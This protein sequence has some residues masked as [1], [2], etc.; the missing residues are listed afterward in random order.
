MDYFDRLG[1]WIE[2]RWVTREEGELPDLAVAALEALPPREQLDLEA[3]IEHVL[4]PDRPAQRQLAPLGAFGQ[5]GFTAYYGRGFVVDVY[6]WTHALSAIHDHPFRGAFTLLAGSS[7]HARYAFE[8]EE[9]RGARVRLG[10]IALERLELL[11]AGHVERFGVGDDGLVHALLHVPIPSV[12]M[13][14]R[15]IRTVGYFRYFPPGVALAMDEPDE[16]VGRQ[17][18]LLDALRVGGDASYRERLERF[19]SRADFEATFR[20]LS[21]VWSAEGDDERERLL[22]LARARHGEAAERIA[23]A[24]DHALRAHEADQARAALRDPDDRFVATAFVLADGRRSLLELLARRHP[25]PLARVHRFLDEA[26]L[27][28]PDEEASNVIAH[29]LADGEGEEG[30]LRRLR[31]VYG[32]EAVEGRGAEVARYC[33]RSMMAVLA[34]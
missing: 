33:E 2:A 1:A 19:L 13:V 34:R 26:G 17:L 22:A 15:T 9:R 12:S 10:R 14:V 7:V 5:P 20:A 29:A 28:A 4:D 6:F 16:L 31:E 23:P 11:E 3:L 32:A 24:L 27:F 25:D 21:R 8:E 18:A 30:A